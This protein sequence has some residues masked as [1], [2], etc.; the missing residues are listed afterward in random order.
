M[1]YTYVFRKPCISYIFI[2]FFN[3]YKI[4]NKIKSVE[5]RKLKFAHCKSV[6]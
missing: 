2:L 3:L 5:K 4:I 1:N 6:M